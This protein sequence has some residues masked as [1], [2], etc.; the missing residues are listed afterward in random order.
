V[1]WPSIAQRPTRNADGCRRHF[2]GEARLEFGDCVMST[3]SAAPGMSPV[4]INKVLRFC[5][6]GHC[7]PPHLDR[8]NRA[9]HH[10]S[11]LAANREPNGF[12]GKGDLM[13][14]R[15]QSIY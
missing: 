6:A 15:Q 1:S 9:L 5:Q 2:L 4:S 3:P 11:P 10:R 7:C 13:S 12:L 8:T 14:P